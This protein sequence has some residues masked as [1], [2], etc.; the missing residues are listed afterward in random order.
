MRLVLELSIESGAEQRAQPKGR[1]A[2][3]LART[4]RWEDSNLRC[5][6]PVCTA[7]SWGTLWGELFKSLIYVCHHR[8][9]NRPSPLL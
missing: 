6:A 2:S 5:E 4:T 8:Q 1:H 9:E 7:W 3:S